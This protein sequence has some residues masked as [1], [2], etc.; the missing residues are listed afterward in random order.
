[1]RQWFSAALEL[2]GLAAV[3]VAAFLV[4]LPLGLFVAGCAA[5]AVGFALERD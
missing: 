1:V 4:A 3:S 2:S 5:F